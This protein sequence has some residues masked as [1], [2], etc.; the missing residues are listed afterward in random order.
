VRLLVDE[1][2]ARWADFVAAYDEAIAE[3]STAWAPWYVVPADRKWVRDTI[4][5]QLLV[6][7]LRG[8]DLRPP[9]ADPELDDIVIE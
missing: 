8:M 7:T 9:V 1:G 3:T 4:V 5:A 2:T 6:M